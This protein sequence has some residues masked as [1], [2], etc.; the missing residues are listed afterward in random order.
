MNRPNK[1]ECYIALGSKNLDRDIHSSLLG[2]F[3]SYKENEVLWIWRREQF[4]FFV[5][6][7][8]AQQARMLNNAWLER[9][10]RDKHS[11]LLD[12]LVSQKENEIL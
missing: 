2:P 7:R 12:Q 10:T 11:I 4:I 3:I 9:F 8:C 1:L 6:Y 5:T